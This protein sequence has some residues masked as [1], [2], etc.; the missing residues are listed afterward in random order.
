MQDYKLV[1]RGVVPGASVF[2]ASG[3]LVY[4]NFSEFQS[5]LNEQYLAQG[6]HII[7]VDTVRTIPATPN[8]PVIYEFAYHLVKDIAEAPAKGK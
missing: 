2:G 7:S 4:Q 5:Q 1:V 3:N 8:T 6:Y